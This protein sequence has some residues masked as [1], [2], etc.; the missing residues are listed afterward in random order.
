MQKLI[1][2]LIGA[3]AIIA[4]PFIAFA[5]V[6]KPV[7]TET[8]SDIIEKAQNLSLQKE[9]LQ[10]VNLLVSAIK[11]ESKKSPVATKELIHSLERIASVFHSDKAQQLFEL[12]ISLKNT[13]PNMALSKLNEALKIEPDNQ[14]I[15]LEQ[16][17]INIMRND[18]SVAAEGLLKY[19][20]INPYSEEVDLVY[21]QAQV[22]AGSFDLYKQIRHKAEDKKSK[23]YPFWAIVDTEYHFK[24]GQ[25]SK[26]KELIK[27]IIQKYPNYPESNFWMWKIDNNE[28]HANKYIN[29]CKSLTIKAQRELNYDPFLCRRTAEVEV[30]LKKNN[31]QNK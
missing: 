21:S 4:A 2:L 31:N 18:C 29:Q 20:E 15:I 5:S 30:F 17:R 3:A 7:T 25:T 11:K 6:A 27:F 13:D 19:K 1:S 28:E 14:S 24:S 16:N 10:A 22:C 26:A 9:R 12:G 23:L 8:A